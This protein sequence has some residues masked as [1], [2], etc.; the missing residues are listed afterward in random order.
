MGTC[1]WKA[2]VK[3]RPPPC[4]LLRGLRAPEHEVLYWGPEAHPRGTSL[5][6]HQRHVAKKQPRGEDLMA[7]TI[8]RF[9]RDVFRSAS[10]PSAWAAAARAD[11]ALP[12]SNYFAAS[13]GFWEELA[14]FDA[15]NASAK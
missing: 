12:W 7:G 13:P 11:P 5:K 8:R 6:E 10:D 2:R 4:D 14:R 15:E 1:S 9:F 3:G